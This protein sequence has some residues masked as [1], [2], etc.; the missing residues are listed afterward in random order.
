MA[1]PA[2]AVTSSSIRRP[3]RS[4]RPVTG[5]APSDASRMMASPTP[6]SVPDSPAWSAKVAPWFTWPNPRATSPRA[7]TTPNCPNPEAKAAT[8]TPATARSFQR[9]NRNPPGWGTGTL[10]GS[11]LNAACLVH[12]MSLRAPM[13]ARR[14][15]PRRCA[16]L[17]DSHQCHRR[18]AEQV[19][20]QAGKHGKITQTFVLALSTAN[21]PGHQR[22]TATGRRAD[23]AQAH[24]NPCYVRQLRQRAHDREP[25]RTA[26]IACPATAELSPS[27]ASRQCPRLQSQVSGE[28]VQA[29]WSRQ[30]GRHCVIV[31]VAPGIAVKP[32]DWPY[33]R[34]EATFNV[35]HGC[36]ELAADR[37]VGGSC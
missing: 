4:A 16:G 9:R 3:K 17:H 33:P 14:G 36:Q 10:P 20:R 11:A 2:P 27:V 29:D 31:N 30:G 21:P 12:N 7:A 35:R 1:S 26:D 24:R 25:Y 8:A 28:H 37:K 13:A 19:P 34:P 23:P 5:S 32:F 15:R 22:A 6:R 18:C